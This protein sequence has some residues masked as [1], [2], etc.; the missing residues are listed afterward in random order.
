L[1]PGRTARPPHVDD[2]VDHARS[3]A[4]ELLVGSE[5]NEVGTNVRR[6]EWL[7][8]E[9]DESDG[10]FLRLASTPRS[11][12]TSITT[13]CGSGRHGPPGD[14]FRR[15]VD[16]VD[17]PVVLCPTTGTWRLADTH[18]SHRRR[19]AAKHV[20]RRTT[21]VRLQG[22][23]WMLV[24]PGGDGERLGEIRLPVLGR[25]NA[26][27]GGAA[28]SDLESSQLRRCRARRRVRRRRPAVPASR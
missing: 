16:G 9:A 7:I 21:G 25:H 12:R 6:G 19:L 18:R 27:R 22:A 5:L 11:S 10:T 15:F 24:R 1:L 14:A 4:P 26:E 8:V 2:H 23:R 13:T 20:G 28:A 3:H 17:G